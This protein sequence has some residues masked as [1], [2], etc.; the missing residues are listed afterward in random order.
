MKTLKILALLLVVLILA[1][2]CSQNHYAKAK[3]KMTEQPKDH[4]PVADNSR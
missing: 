3:R 1:G 2:S 4:A